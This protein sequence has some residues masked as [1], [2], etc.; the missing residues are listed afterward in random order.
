M[1]MYACTCT[2]YMHVQVLLKEHTYK[3]VQVCKVHANVHVHGVCTLARG[4][5]GERKDGWWEGEE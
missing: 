3:C 1:Y 5:E 2:L 4:D